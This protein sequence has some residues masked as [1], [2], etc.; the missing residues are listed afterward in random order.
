MATAG[1]IVIDLLLRTGSFE[2]DTKRAERSMRSMQSTAQDVSKGIVSGFASIA[3]V[4]GG[5]LGA[6]A[7]VD[8]AIRG[9]SNAINAA[10]RLDELSARYNIA[11]ETLAGWGYAAK[12]TGSDLEGL[13]AG[14]PRFTKNLADAADASST[15][16]KTFAA[17]GISIKD[18]AGNLR[19]F[20]DLLPE[21]MDRFAGMSNET[22]KT[23]TAMQLFG[24]SGAEFLEFLSLGSSGLQGMED[25]A[26]ALGIVIDS[27]TAGAAAAFNDRVDDLRAATQGWFTQLAAQLLPTLTDLTVK[28]TD[29]VREGGGVRDVASGIA[30]AFREIAQAAELLAGVE[31]WLDRIRG[32][33]VAVEKQGNAVLKL[34]T[35]QYAF[36]G[37]G[38]SQFAKDYQA[39][40][41]YADTG[42]KAQQSAATA[43]QVQLIDPS[44]GLDAWKATN[45]QKKK[46]AE[47]EARLQALME[48]T[49]EK[50]KSSGKKVKDAAKDAADE[51][52]KAYQAIYGNDDTTKAG[53]LIDQLNREISLHGQVGEAAKVAYDIKAGAYGALTEDQAAYML[54]LA[55]TKDALDDF[56]AIYGNIADKAKES[57]S[58]ISTYADQ[59]A[60]NMQDAFADFLFDPFSEGLGG[61]VKSFAEAL[62]KMAAQAAASQI[63]SA[64]GGWASSY[65]GAGSGWIN[66]IGGTISGKRA[67]G[68]SVNGSGLYEVG[69]GGRPELFQDAS[70][71]TYLIPG[72]DGS[73]SPITAGATSAGVLDTRSGNVRVEVIN[74]GSPASA[75]ATTSTQPDGTQL[76]KIFMDAVA[77]NVASGGS[78]ARAGKARFGWKELV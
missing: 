77:D 15:A 18:Q 67:G 19:S 17:L 70:G 14:I 36:G 20:Q 60:R 13:A 53:Q 65:T 69:E 21:V 45:E 73:V 62:Q 72:N 49:G 39:G 52:E 37:G 57:T 76:I 50:A 9:L 12:M 8:T 63:F 22:V 27:E 11:T 28:F 7:S 30:D 59:A 71:K 16:G 26:K 41:A 48:G 46:A 31:K 78:V 35:G 58:A 5:A 42:W 29:L 33:L 64:I 54:S 2:T 74:N 3:G 47:Y 32:G 6:I 10:D 38:W 68:G 61:M 1:S 40:T 23:A 66:A 25:R 55:Q 44:E 24:K 34:T 75:T 56:D 51:I 4:V 43:P